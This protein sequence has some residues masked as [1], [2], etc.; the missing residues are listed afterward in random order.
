MFFV[1][2]GEEISWG[3][4]ILG[5]A[6]PESLKAVNVQEE[7][8]FHNID[9]IHQHVR[10]VG[11]LSAAFFCYLIPLSNRFLP[12]CRRL[13]RH[14]RLPIFSAGSAMLVTI[15]IAFMAVPRLLSSRAFIIDEIGEFYLAIAC[16]IFAIE[17][18]VLAAKS[19]SDIGISR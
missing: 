6:T 1:L 4:R 5:I 17:S 9:G 7:F 13:Y 18:F 3:Q 10:L 15:A 11:V 16:L 19:R 12:G 2:A 8:N 14:Y